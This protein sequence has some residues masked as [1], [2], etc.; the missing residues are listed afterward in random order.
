ML[1]GAGKLL[2]KLIFN[3][4]NGHLDRGAGL[5]PNQFGFR[6]G[7]GTLEAVEAVIR[8]DESAV[9]G[10]IRD[11]QLCVLVT[12]DVKNAFNSA[13]ID[14]AAAGFGLPTYLLRSYLSDRQITVPASSGNVEW[15]A[16]SHRDR[17]SGQHCGTFF[18]THY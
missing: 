2:E 3:R 5:A 10:V 16:V 6:S 12:L 17:F 8:V 9:R 4:I 15:P 11:R 18:M 1:D 7:R 13:L 14:S